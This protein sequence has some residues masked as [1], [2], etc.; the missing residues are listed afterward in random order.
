MA[1]ARDNHGRPAEGRQTELPATDAGAP[2]AGP[3]FFLAVYQGGFSEARIFRAYP[4]SDGISF[5]YTGPPGPFLDLEIARTPERGG[6]RVTAA[7]ALKSG[8]VRMGGAALFVLAIVVAVVGRAALRGNASDITD[9]IGFLV[10]VFTVFAFAILLAMTMSVRRIIARVAVLDAMSREEI[11][12]EAKT[13]KRSLRATADNVSD[14]CIDPPPRDDA[15]DCAARLSFR[16][17]PTG[18]WK[19]ILVARKDVRLAARAFRA[20]LGEDE[21]EVNVSLKRV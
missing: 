11:L 1:S 5:V 15:L 16:H 20:L 7:E 2:E 17:D 3:K 9:L 21:V 14:V 4:D 13:E 19:L 18:K 8:L 12:N 10:M 6:W